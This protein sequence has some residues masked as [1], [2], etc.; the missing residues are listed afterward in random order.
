MRLLKKQQTIA[1]ENLDRRVFL[2][3]SAG[4]GKTT[5]A[6]ERI[7]T[8]IKE[9]VPAESILVLVPQ[10]ALGLPYTD[11]LR[12]SRVKAGTNITVM[13]LGRLAFS[14]VDL[15]WPLL[16]DDSGVARP[17][18]RPNFLSLEMVQ[19][20]MA[21][22]VG[23]EIDRRDYFNGVPISRNRLYTQVADNL[24]KAA[25]VGFSHET[26]SYRLK[27]AWQG[28]VSQAFIYDD[29]QAVA[30]LFRDSCLQYNL[31]DFSLQV[32]LFWRAWQ[33][34]ESVQNYLVSRYR[35]LIVDNIEEDTP[36][37]HDMLRDWLP[38]C[39]SALLI[40]DNDAGFRQFL[41]ADPVDAEDLKDLCEVKESLDNHR[42]M[43][44]DVEAFQIEI[45]HSLNIPNDDKLPKGSDAR[46]A[47]AYP[48]EAIRYHPQMVDWVVDSVQALIRDEG[49]PP[50]EII[51]LSAFLPDALRF[52]LQTRFDERGIPNRSHRPSRALRDEPAART[53]LTLAKL[54]HP[55]WQFQPSSYDLTYALSASIDE[56]DLVRAR[57]LTDI[58]YRGGE[59]LPFER[60]QDAKA[61]NRITFELAERY[62]KLR[63]WIERYQKKGEQ[64][65]DIFFS[66]LFG[67]VISQPKFGFHGKFDAARTAANLIDSA[68]GFR[69]TV[70]KVE[71]DLPTSEEYVRM[72]DAGVLANQ[73]LRDWETEKKD[74]VLIA[75]AYTFLMNNQPVDYQFWLNIGSSGWGQR[76]NQ[77]LTHAY[78]LSRQWEVG[79]QWTDTD[80][81]QANLDT[82][83]H[84]IL[85]LIR[86]C[87]KRIYLG[88][89]EFGEQGFAER[90]PLLQVVQ[91]TLRRL[92]KEQVNV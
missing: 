51:V 38:Q 24:S 22:F 78:I 54:A 3:G 73:Y 18:K 40:Y 31:L 75:P 5:A 2:E 83:H 7:K 64:P 59:L 26:I 8:L 53:L 90:G 55:Q 69:Q 39:D 17:M 47:L 15:F 12:R 62:E 63:K 29:A 88:Y 72:V 23:Q 14:I 41:G 57:L 43:E 80:E 60:I 50:S 25:V 9:G 87:R 77:P 37:M 61:Q 10:A 11:A 58:L 79:R 49:V 34:Y 36:V 86:R 20:Y 74:S 27:T 44:P 52:S 82:L 30:T 21:R 85:G 71:P 32:E 35:H 48:A 46:D 4:T 56:L 33:Q 91:S 76:L 65:L 68:R 42:V 6:I 1:N 16:A 13:T 67:E 66:K 19:Y 84:L 28:D 89:S 92:S 70:N 45:T 81:E